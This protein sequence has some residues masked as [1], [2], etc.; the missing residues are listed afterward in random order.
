[1]KKNKNSGSRTLLWSVIMSSPGPI[2]VGIGLLMGKSATQIA[3]F[4][5]RSAELAAIIISFVIYRATTSEGFD[6]TEKRKRLEKKADMFVGAAMCLGGAMMLLLAVLSGNSETGNVIPGLCVAL[7]GVTANSIFWIKYS[8]I[9]GESGNSILAVQSRLYRAKTF[10]DACVS[11]ALISV[12]LFPGTAAAYYL[13]KAGSAA[14]AL[15]L[16]RTGIKTIREHT[17]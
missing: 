7:L 9:A 5:R 3:D 11:A 6:D 17:S 15:Y 4:V 1:M 10:V 14:V 12:V 2:V 16:M 8:R 13:D